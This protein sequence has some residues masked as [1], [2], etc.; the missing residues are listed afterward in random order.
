MHNNP[1]G[2]TSRCAPP[3]LTPAFCLE[4]PID[5]T[6][7][8]E[9][10]KTCANESS[11]RIWQTTHDLRYTTLHDNF[12]A[13]REV[14]ATLLRHST[15]NGMTSSQMANSNNHSQLLQ[16]ECVDLPAPGVSAPATPPRRRSLRTRHCKENDPAR[17]NTRPL[18]LTS[19]LQLT[20]TFAW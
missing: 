5:L 20:N 14:A 16:H 6:I 15:S 3:S 18:S 7:L 13:T 1:R 10:R 2:R 4:Y 12:C 8:W 11:K 17:E 19:F 9:E